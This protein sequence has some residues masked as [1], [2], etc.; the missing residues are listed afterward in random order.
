MFEG[1]KG[2]KLPTFMTDTERLMAVKN[3]GKD[4]LWHFPVCIFLGRWVSEGLD[5]CEVVWTQFCMDMAT[6]L[7]CEHLHG[8][9][10]CCTASDALRLMTEPAENDEE[11]LLVMPKPLAGP[12]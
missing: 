5:G 9:T 4:I 8:C 6:V 11:A 7:G 10:A 2:L 12:Q 3:I 1:C